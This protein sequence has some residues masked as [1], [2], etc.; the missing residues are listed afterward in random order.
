MRFRHMLQAFAFCLSM[1]AVC[2]AQ[3]CPGGPTVNFPDGGGTSTCEEE[4]DGRYN[5]TINLT[6]TAITVVI[7]VRA[8]TSHD[9]RQIRII[10]DTGERGWL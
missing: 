3:T 9:I 10:T 7:E 8:T 1:A 2:T 5:I 4:N 6:T